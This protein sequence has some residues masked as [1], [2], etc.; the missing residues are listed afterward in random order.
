MVLV[1]VATVVGAWLAR[2]GSGRPAL[3]PAAVSGILLIIA[4]LD[5]LPDAW[6][7]A[8]EAGVPQ[9]T[10]PLTALASVRG[11]GRRDPYGLPVRARSCGRLGAASGLALR[12]SLEGAT[13]A[14]TASVAV[15]AALLVH[16]VGEGLSP[17]TSAL[18][19]PDSLM[20]LLLRL[21]RRRTRAGGVGGAETLT[22]LAVLVGAV[23]R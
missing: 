17:A 14:L 20:P 21:R 11:D 23:N 2:R 9:W 5:P 7:E 13:L 1:T 15:V 8:H 12:R 6:D 10:V 22:A 4:V 19:I 16:A 3:L 18:P